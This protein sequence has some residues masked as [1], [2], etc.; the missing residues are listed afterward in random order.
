MAVAGR[1]WVEEVRDAELSRRGD[2]AL[3]LEEQDLVPEKGIADGFEVKI[4]NRQTAGKT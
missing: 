2:M 4:F 3:A 1:S